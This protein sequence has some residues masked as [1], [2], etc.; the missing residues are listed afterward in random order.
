MSKVS[1]TVSAVD[2][3]EDD[4]DMQRLKDEV[5]VLRGVADMYAHCLIEQHSL[6]KINLMNIGM[7]HLINWYGEEDEQDN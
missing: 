5:V 7:G 2:K 1:W 3:Y 4:K 6:G